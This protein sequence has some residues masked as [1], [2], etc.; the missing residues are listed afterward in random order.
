[1]LLKLI[2]V[3]KD[4]VAPLSIFCATLNCPTPSWPTANLT[5]CVGSF[6]NSA[7]TVRLK[8][9]F[10]MESPLPCLKTKPHEV[11]ELTLWKKPALKLLDL[12]GSP[13][14]ALSSKSP[15]LYPHLTA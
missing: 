11:E 7:P 6:T 12:P 13:T 2:L 1:M 8:S 5:V 4:K 10:L 9:L 15:V 3:C 14:V